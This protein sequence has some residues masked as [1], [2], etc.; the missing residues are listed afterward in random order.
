MSLILE[1]KKCQVCGKFYNWNPDIGKIACPYCRALPIEIKK[2]SKI[3]MA[4][5]YAKGLTQNEL[6]QRK[7][8]LYR[9]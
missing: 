4:K 6:L 3:Q 7:N 5:K 9:E 2:N 8:C 1:K